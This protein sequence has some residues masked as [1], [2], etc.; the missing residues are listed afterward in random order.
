MYKDKMLVM[1]VSRA[2][3]FQGA[4]LRLISRAARFHYCITQN[5]MADVNDLQ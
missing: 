5:A 1:R 4:L 2:E 3:I